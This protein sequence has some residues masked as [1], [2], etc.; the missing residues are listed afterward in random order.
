MMMMN[1]GVGNAKSDEYHFFSFSSVTCQPLTN[2]NLLFIWLSY[3]FCHLSNMN[4]LMVGFRSVYGIFGLDMSV[5]SAFFAA[6]STFYF[7]VYHC[8]LVSRWEWCYYFL[9][10]PG[11]HWCNSFR[12]CCLR[13]CGIITQ[14]PQSRHRFSMLSLY[15]FVWNAE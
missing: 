2:N 6:L 14:D 1:V 15:L 8:G 4:L 10:I 13:V 5:R 3:D 9:T 7:Y 12:T 11:W